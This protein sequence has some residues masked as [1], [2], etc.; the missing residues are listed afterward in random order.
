MAHRQTYCVKY[1]N[2]VCLFLIP[3]QVHSFGFEYF[4]SSGLTVDP[5][6]HTLKKKKIPFK[7]LI[8]ISLEN[9]INSTNK[10]KGCA[11]CLMDKKK[12]HE[13]FY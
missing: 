1:Y 9:I 13:P 6:L 10:Q 11:D 12:V 4:N 2:L 8:F 3:L 5:S 7:D